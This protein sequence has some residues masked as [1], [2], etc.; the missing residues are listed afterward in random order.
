MLQDNWALMPQ[1]EKPTCPRARD[2][3][4][5]KPVLQQDSDPCSPQLE[6]SPHGNEDPVQPNINKW[7]LKTKSGQLSL[8][9]IHSLNTHTELFAKGRDTGEPIS[10]FSKARFPLRPSSV[11]Q[12]HGLAC[13]GTMTLSGAGFEVW[14][15]PAKEGEKG[16][17][18]RTAESQSLGGE[19]LSMSYPGCFHGDDH[20]W[21]DTHQTDHDLDCHDCQLVPPPRRWSSKV[22]SGKNIQP[23]ILY[24]ARLFFRY[25]GKIKGFTDKQKLREFGTTKPALQQMLR[26]LP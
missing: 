18:E 12:G 11:S 19:I 14:R 3:Q 26:E 23:R 9:W 13:W 5:E 6:K 17:G 20:P 22:L 21:A 2:P 24:P 15:R 25:R 10:P 7:K 8:L 1:L 4:Q 16:V